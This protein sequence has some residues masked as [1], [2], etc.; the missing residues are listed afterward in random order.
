VLQREQQEAERLLRALH[1]GVVG[2]WRV[3]LDACEPAPL[4][5][6]YN[7]PVLALL[8]PGAQPAALDVRLPAPP[9]PR[10][11]PFAKPTELAFGAARLRISE[12]GLDP[13]IEPFLGDGRG[14]VLSG[15]GIDVWIGKGL[16]GAVPAG[17]RWT[18]AVLA[19]SLG[20]GAIDGWLP[21][22]G[23]PAVLGKKGASAEIALEYL[24]W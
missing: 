13:Q 3:R 21:D 12:A 15:R 24:D 11:H 20:G 19:V 4:S 5:E 14:S 8:V 22:G 6:R 2:I 7:P 10:P 1:Q 23:D 16:L 9:R 17:S 18:G